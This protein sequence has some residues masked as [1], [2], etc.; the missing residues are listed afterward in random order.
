MEWSKHFERCAWC[1][2]RIIGLGCKPS[3]Y[4]VT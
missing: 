1:Q 4:E 3:M 2:R